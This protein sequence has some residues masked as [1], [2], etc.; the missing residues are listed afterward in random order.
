MTEFREVCARAGISPKP[1]SGAGWLAAALLEKH[2]VPK[3]PLSAKEK[4]EIAARPPSEKRKPTKPRR[5]ERDPQFEIVANNA[6]Y[7][8]RF[9]I[10]R[11]GAIRGPVY[12]YDLQSAYCAA[13][14]KLPCPLHSRWEHR[15]RATKLPHGELC[16]AKVSFSHPDRSLWCGF[17]FRQSRG[18]FWP[19]QGT[20]WY[21]SPEISSSTFTPTQSC[22]IYGLRGVN[23]IASHSTGLRL[24]TKSGGGSGRIPGGVPSK[25]G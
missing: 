21:W 3:R 5:S 9:E 22:S 10:S 4:S 16:L 8:G 20:G 7:G 6:Y 12:E 24:S 13:T 17:P 2:G 15:P 19:Y 25:S 11:I 14:L 18:L 1:W 23:V